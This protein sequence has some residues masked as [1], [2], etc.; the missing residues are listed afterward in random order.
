MF[1]FLQF[2]DI[3]E[4]CNHQRTASKVKRLRRS[5]CHGQRSAILSLN[6][7]AC[8]RQR[9]GRWVLE[10]RQNALPLCLGMEQNHM[11]SN[12]FAPGIPRQELRGRVGIDNDSSIG[13]NCNR[14]V[15]RMLPA[16][17]I[18]TVGS[19]DIGGCHSR[20]PF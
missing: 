1:A 5:D 19:A 9:M 12:Q 7:K 4:L 20:R 14:T 11:R 15:L 8:V 18:K 16:E 17:L 6:V 3:A 13:L 2:S 10:L